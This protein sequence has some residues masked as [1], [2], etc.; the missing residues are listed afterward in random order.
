MGKAFLGSQALSYA[1]ST[2]LNQG[3]GW[4]QL[5]HTRRTPGLSRG[6]TSLALSPRKMFS[7]ITAYEPPVP[8]AIFY[9][10]EEEEAAQ[11]LC[12]LS[13]PH[14]SPAHSARDRL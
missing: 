12:A 10:T 8:D 2:H 14:S 13:Q 11:R 4:L 9:H 6:H 7:A 1:L 5:Y 3:K